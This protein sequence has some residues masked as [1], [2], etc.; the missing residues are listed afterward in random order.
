MVKL[1]L[2][3][4]AALVL[5]DW[6]VLLTN[7]NPNPLTY[8]MTTVTSS[9]LPQTALEMSRE[10]YSSLPGWKQVNLKKAIGLF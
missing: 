7:P 9:L 4:H 6:M 5:Q 10:E 2:I 3:M 8:G 1:E